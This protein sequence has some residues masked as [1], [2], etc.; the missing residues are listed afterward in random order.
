MKTCPRLAPREHQEAGELSASQASPCKTVLKDKAHRGEERSTNAQHAPVR[1]LPW[2]T[3]AP[4]CGHRNRTSEATNAPSPSGTTTL[5]GTS[6]AF[7]SS[8]SSENL[9]QCLRE[10]DGLRAGTEPLE[11]VDGK[12]IDLVIITIGDRVHGRD[13]LRGISTEDDSPGPVADDDFSVGRQ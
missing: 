12:L 3:A 5:L 1:L 11:A 7:C 8:W 4:T 2:S 6:P 10:T 9:D 13:R